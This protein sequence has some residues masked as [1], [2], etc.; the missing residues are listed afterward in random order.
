M[1]TESHTGFELRSPSLFLTTLTIVP[2]AIQF[3]SW[4]VLV[5]IWS[6]LFL[7]YVCLCA[8]CRAYLESHWPITENWCTINLIL[9]VAWDKNRMVNTVYKQYSIKRIFD[10]CH[11]GWLSLL[12]TY[13]YQSENECI[14]LLIVDTSQLETDYCYWSLLLKVSLLTVSY[15]FGES[16]RYCGYD[17]GL[18]TR[19]NHLRTPF[20]IWH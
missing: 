16:Q 14:N 3:Y 2:R 7:Y 19:C 11:C 17:S 10:P 4:Y 6:P 20:S 1:N 18:Q 9:S 12:W 8:L 15:S 13:I 5:S